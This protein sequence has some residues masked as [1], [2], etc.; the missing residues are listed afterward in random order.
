MEQTS[1]KNFNEGQ[2]QYWINEID[3]S[4]ERYTKFDT[5]ILAWTRMENLF[6]SHNQSEWS[7]LQILS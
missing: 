5:S 6:R 4:Q 3:E 2:E 7:M 1:V